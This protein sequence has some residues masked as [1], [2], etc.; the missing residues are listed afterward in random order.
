V[1]AKSGVL[2]LMRAV[3]EDEREAGVRANAL[4][5]TA[6]RTARN[7]AE[8]GEGVAYVSR[9]EVGAI[10]AWLCSDAARSITGQAIRLGA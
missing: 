6:I 7:L 4:A 8:M 2:A 5:P 9:E 3:A 1:A 10:V